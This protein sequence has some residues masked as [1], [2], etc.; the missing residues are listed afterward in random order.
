MGWLIEGV[1]ATRDG[2]TWDADVSCIEHAGGS[3]EVSLPDNSVRI[4]QIKWTVERDRE[5]EIV[6]WKAV[7]HG[8]SLTIFND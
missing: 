6:A 2:T 8:M 5:N 1:W 4:S 3:R 7:A